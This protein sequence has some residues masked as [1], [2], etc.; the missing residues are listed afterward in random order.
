MKHNDEKC[1]QSLF[2]PL[3]IL[4]IVKESMERELGDSS[5]ETEQLIGRR[6]INPTAEHTTK[7]F[8]PSL[9]NLMRTSASRPELQRISSSVTL[10]ASRIQSR[11]G[12]NRLYE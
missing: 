1:T 5:E 8:I 6:T 12:R 11:D 10:T 7:N 3:G 9:K 4:E 2:D